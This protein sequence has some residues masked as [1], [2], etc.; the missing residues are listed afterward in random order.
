MR[1]TEVTLTTWV[2]AILNLFGY[3]LLLGPRRPRNVEV[4]LVF[5]TL[6]IGAGYVVLWFYWQGHNWARILVFLTC[7]LC[8]YNLRSFGSANFLVRIMLVGEAVVGVFLVY[9]LNTARARAF[10]QR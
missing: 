7:F 1:P 4:A 9:W 3:A 10:F 6:M 5:V 2:M 8:F